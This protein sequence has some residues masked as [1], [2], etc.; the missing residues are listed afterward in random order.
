MSEKERVIRFDLKYW[1]NISFQNKQITYRI[2]CHN[3]RLKF[4]DISL[5][6]ALERTK[7]HHQPRQSIR[8]S[9]VQKAKGFTFSSCNRG[10]KILKNFQ[11][12]A[13]QNTR[14][15]SPYISVGQKISRSDRT[16]PFCRV[17]LDIRWQK[18]FKEERNERFFKDGPKMCSESVLKKV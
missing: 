3:A 13:E 7:K 12:R 2:L 9:R 4:H 11:L 14:F 15:L 8:R 16:A 18:V 17:H 6:M 1:E 5:F 10:E